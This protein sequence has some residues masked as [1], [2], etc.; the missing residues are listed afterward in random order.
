MRIFNYRVIL[1]KEQDSG[2]TAMVPALPGCITYGKNLEQAM[3]MVKEAI[4]L[5]LESLTSH[6]EPI[7][8]E[9][10]TLEYMASIQ[11]H[12][13]TPHRRIFF[14]TPTYI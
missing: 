10:S 8:N 3:A 6:H 7:P 12:A 13:C 2:H 4:E 11:A 14:L 1:K 9:E 5:Y